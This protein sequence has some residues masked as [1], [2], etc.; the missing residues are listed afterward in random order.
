MVRTVSDTR[1]EETDSSG[2]LIKSLL[3]ENGHKVTFYKI[4][5]DVPVLIRDTIAEAVTDNYI[6]A[7]IV[8]GGTGISKRDTTFEAIDGLLEKRLEGYGELFRYLS[9]QEI[10]SGDFLCMMIISLLIGPM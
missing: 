10:G 2:R 3:K 6:Q 5:K 8:N 1:T 9:F 4:L 7:I